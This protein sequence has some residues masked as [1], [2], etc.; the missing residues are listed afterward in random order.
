MTSLALLVCA[1]VSLSL[2]HPA[3]DPLVWGAD[4]HRMAARAAVDALPGEIPAFFTRAGDRLVYLNPEPDRWR[5]PPLREMDQAWSYDHYIDLE[6]VP[7]GAL[8]APDRFV[9]LRELYDA[10]LAKPER[11]A[12]FLPF[13]IVELYQRLVTEWRM[14]RVASGPERVWIEQRIVNDAGILGHYV[15]DASQP[16]HTTIHFNGW[17]AGRKPG[18]TNPNGYTESNDFHGRFEADFVRRHVDPEWVGRAVPP[19]THSVAGTARAGVIAYIMES[20]THVEELYRLERDHGFDPEGPADEAA[21]RFAVD[22]LAA[23]GAMLRTLWWSAWL[24]SASEAEA[25]GR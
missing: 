2:A 22:R 7:P 6:N 3:P 10:G 17:N 15:T 14:W 8:D 16:H 20:H 13:R 19:S 18:V 24:E 5:S 11:D 9:F 25:Q 4:G 1:T 12:G 21:V 23:G